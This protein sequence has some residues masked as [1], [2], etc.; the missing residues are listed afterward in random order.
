M[1]P[2]GL[3]LK[4]RKL[5]ILIIL[6]GCHVTLYGLNAVCRLGHPLLRF[7]YSLS[8]RVGIAKDGFSP[9]GMTILVI[10]HVDFDLPARQ[11]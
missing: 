8:R 4:P 6:S 1:R 10:L 2:N 5:P 7:S 9:V 3:E 11:L